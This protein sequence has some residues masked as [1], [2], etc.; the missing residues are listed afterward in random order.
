MVRALVVPAHSLTR[1][2][3]FLRLMHRLN[4]L[5]KTLSRFTQLLLAA[6][7]FAKSDVQPLLNEGAA[8]P[9]L[10]LLSFRPL[11]TRPSLAWLCGHPIRGYGAFLGGPLQY[12]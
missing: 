10:P 8:Q 6:A 9:I 1:W 11:Q 12:L 7:F 5:A 2:H 4:E 3:L